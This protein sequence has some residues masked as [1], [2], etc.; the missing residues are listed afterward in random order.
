MRRS[1]IVF[2]CAVATVCAGVIVATAAS[3]HQRSGP[4]VAAS[5][6]RPLCTED[7][8]TC[9]ETVDPIG[10]E[11]AYTG[12]DEPA[13]LFYS[14]TKGSGNS[15]FYQLTIPTDAQV[16]PQQNGNGGTDN[17]QLH[18]A[19]WFGMAMCD[20]ESAPEYTHV[21][22]PDTDNNIY[23]SGNPESPRYIGKH[24]GTAFMEMQFYPPGWLQWPPG[25]S[26]DPTRWCAALNIDSFS[27]DMNTGAVNNGGCLN[28]VGIE[29]VNFAFLTISGH[30]HAPA[31]PVS[32]A[33]NPATGTPNPATDLFMNSGDRLIV[34]MYDTPD[35]FQ[36]T[37]NDTTTGQVGSMTASKANGFGQIKFDPNGNGCTVIPY[38]FHPMYAT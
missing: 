21:C 6:S 2:T 27:E 38:A 15:N 31:D 5:G 14:R 20:S 36:V 34:G 22:N 11:G 33:T 10:Y 12:H 37:V 30:S 4:A 9:T 26:C 24:P 17:F 29:P 8:S 18:P 28:T 32:F 1:R 16:P 3:Q 23:N 19:F 13:V 7:A 35:G 25:D